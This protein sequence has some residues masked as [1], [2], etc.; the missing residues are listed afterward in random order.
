[1][2]QSKQEN[3]KAPKK[4]SKGVTHNLGLDPKGVFT[5]RVGGEKGAVFNVMLLHDYLES[6][7][8]S[9]YSM[10]KVS[11]SKITCIQNRSRFKAFVCLSSVEFVPKFFSDKNGVFECLVN[12]IWRKCQFFDQYQKQY[13]LKSKTHVQSLV[14]NGANGLEH[15][16]LHRLSSSVS[17]SFAVLPITSKKAAK[18]V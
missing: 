15:A 3:K 18:A 16:V 10:K 4:Q 14:Y 8:M 17:N 13:G 2:E 1:M 9:K 6:V 12:G 5:V 7:A 11:E